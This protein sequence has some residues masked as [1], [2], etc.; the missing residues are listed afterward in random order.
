MM[1]ADARFMRRALE[2]A[3]RARGLTSPNPMV[4]AVLVRDGAVVAEGFH[5]RAGASQA[6]VEALARAGEGARGATLYVT[7]EPCIHHGRTPPCAPAV[8]AA[9]VAHVVARSPI[10][11]RSCPGGASR[12]CAMPAST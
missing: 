6:E 8:I 12:R 7:L 5:Q 2:L 4:G 3:V 1:A 10:R 11:I 9:G